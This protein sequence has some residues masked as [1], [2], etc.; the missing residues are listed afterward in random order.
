[1]QLSPLQSR[2]AASLAASLLL[3]LLYL[4]LASPKFALAAELPLDSHQHSSRDLYQDSYRAL[5]ALSG[6]P[7]S[8]VQQSSLYTPAFGLFEPSIVGRAAAGAISLQLD[9]PRAINVASGTTVCF[10]VEKSVLLGE[11]GSAVAA[12][13]QLKRANTDDG[14]KRLYLSANTCRQPLSSAGGDG[15]TPLQLILSVSNTTD[16]RC[17]S[18]SNPPKDGQDKAFREGAVTYGV[19]ATGD[20]YIGVTAPNASALAQGVYNVELAASRRD[21]FHQYGGGKKAMLLWMDSD[22]SSALLVTRNLTHKRSDI[23]RIMGQDPPYELFVSNKNWTAMNGMR[24]SACGL[25][26]SAQIVVD[27][28]SSNRENSPARTMMTLRGPGGFP[29]QEFYFV[30]LNASTTYT[31]ILVKKPSVGARQTRQEDG[32]GGGGGGFASGSIVFAAT[33]FDTVSGATKLGRAELEGARWLT[34]R[35]EPT[36]AS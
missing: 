23:A 29:K 22:S 20:I 11:P 3:L 36:A 5:E 15:S 25:R 16:G 13:Q 1:M 31:G 12:R 30:A 27:S 7:E 9:Q 24:Q 35:Q 14:S 28:S 10:V 26:N 4:L 6:A 33:D 8:D 34:P 18:A 19:N 17:P 2:L 21:Y 32:G